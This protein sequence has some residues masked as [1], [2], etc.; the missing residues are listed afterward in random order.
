MAGSSRPICMPD[1]Q[2]AHDPAVTIS[3]TEV[4][5][6]S[7]QDGVA[8][9][10][11]EPALNGAARSPAQPPWV[12]LL[13]PANPA[14]DEALGPSPAFFPGAPGLRTSGRDGA[15]SPFQSPASA[16]RAAGVPARATGVEA[17]AGTSTST[18]GPSSTVTAEPPNGTS[19]AGQAKAQAGAAA[20]ARALSSLASEPTVNAAKV[21][22]GQEAKK[23]DQRPPRHLA[24]P[25]ADEGQPAGPQEPDPHN[26]D[27]LPTRRKG[28]LGLRWR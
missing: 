4:A 12:A 15:P 27:I 7:T 18:A 1:P 16:R 28:F 6:P 3:R 17:P 8:R 13:T 22:A 20:A 9:F 2:S 23:G 19:P 10:A 5:S 14:G 26:D 24:G 11:G 21:R 25:Q